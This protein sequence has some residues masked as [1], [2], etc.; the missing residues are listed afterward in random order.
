MKKIKIIALLLVIS[1]T[2]GFFTSAQAYSSGDTVTFTAS[3]EKNHTSGYDNTSGNTVKANEQDS[4]NSSM[5][6][7]M[8]KK[9]INGIVENSGNNHSDN[10]TL[11]NDR[12]I[13]QQTYYPTKQW[14]TDFLNFGLNMGQGGNFDG[15]YFW[16]DNDFSKAQASAGKTIE[17]TG[18]LAVRNTIMNIMADDYNF[19][20]SKDFSNF[21]NKFAW[22]ISMP[23]NTP[24]NIKKALEKYQK[25]LSA[26]SKYGLTPIR[27]DLVSSIGKGIVDF[28]SYKNRMNALNDYLKAFAANDYIKTQYI[29]EIKLEGVKDQQLWQSKVKT[30]GLTGQTH[31]WQFECVESN[32]GNHPIMEQ[33]G[34]NEVKQTFFYPGKYQ[35][36]ATQI[37]EDIKAQAISYTVNEYWVVADTG[38]VI[39]KLETKGDPLPNE[40]STPVSELN[41]KN[42]VNTTSMESQDRYVTV[43]NQSVNVTQQNYIG[44]LAAPSVWGANF[45]TYRIK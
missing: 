2:A 44:S 39:F 12:Y 1:L 28:S 6:D 20:L 37:I 19:D 23:T 35:V 7:K 38:Q 31:Y 13:A 5:L 25:E 40:N 21:K 17:K 15:S 16:I 14:L 29:C 24:E 32:T 36:S 8:E 43:Y 3:T 34:G 9:F 27:N 18:S 4:V 11:L 41:L 33:F 45:D 42:V 30:W 22:D 26:L 10:F